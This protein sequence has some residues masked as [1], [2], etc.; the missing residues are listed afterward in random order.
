[1]HFNFELIFAVKFYYKMKVL[2]NLNIDVFSMSNWKEKTKKKQTRKQRQYFKLFT[3]HSWQDWSPFLSHTYFMASN[4]W[5]P[6]ISTAIDDCY[7]CSPSLSTGETWGTSHNTVGWHNRCNNWSTGCFTAHF[8]STL[9]F[10]Q[11]ALRRVLFV[12]LRGKGGERE[13]F[14]WKC[15]RYND[16]VLKWELLIEHTRVFI[17]LEDNK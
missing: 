2:R 8:I 13:L 14:S 3:K 6:T 15:F 10:L 5:F 12:L 16:Y 7:I 1:M 17:L 11:T 4:L 9:N